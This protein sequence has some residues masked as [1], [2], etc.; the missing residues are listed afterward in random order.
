MLPFIRALIIGWSLISIA[1]SYYM[2]DLMKNDFTEEQYYFT[3]LKSSEK[4]TGSNDDSEVRII[5]EELS[6]RGAFKQFLE[7]LKE[8]AEFGG[9]YV[10]YVDVEPKFYL[11]FPIYVF[12]I[13]SIPILVFCI[14]SFTFKKRN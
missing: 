13:W 7:Q 9:K 2:F 12:L 11:L 14:L 10:E 5:L 4:L 8:D 1:I 6:R 3:Y